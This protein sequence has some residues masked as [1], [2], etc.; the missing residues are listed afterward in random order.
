MKKNDEQGRMK[1]FASRAKSWTISRIYHCCCNF[2]STSLTISMVLFRNVSLFPEENQQPISASHQLP[3]DVKQ[4][5]TFY[6]RKSK[7][8]KFAK[9]SHS[10]I[11]YSFTII[12][13]ATT[14]Q[15]QQHQQHHHSTNS[16][17]HHNQ[18]PHN[19]PPPPPALPPPTA[20]NH[21]RPSTPNCS[22]DDEADAADDDDKHTYQSFCRNLGHGPLVSCL[23]EIRP[24]SKSHASTFC[25]QVPKLTF[26]SVSLC[27]RKMQLTRTQSITNRL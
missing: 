12:N 19:Q 8:N 27:V 18:P 4:K 16:T 14:Q 25:A 23:P 21:P 1:K 10:N 9:V 11:F 5:H 26:R 15:H 22:N 20:T 6:R 13:H 3:S 7:K 2:S 17:N 24:N